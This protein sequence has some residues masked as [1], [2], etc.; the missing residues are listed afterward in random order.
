MAVRRIPHGTITLA[1]HQL[2][3]GDGEP[4]LLLHELGGASGSWAAAVEPWPGA[5]FALDLAGHGASEWRPGGAY[6]PELFAA[7]VDAAVAVLGPCRVAGAGLGAY[8]ALL[9]AGARPDLVAA[10]LL[11]PGRGLDGGGPLPDPAR[12]VPAGMESG[13][14]GSDPMVRACETD[15]RPVDYARA[16]ARGARQ[17]LLAEDGSARPPWWHG[18]REAPGVRS[19]PADPAVALRSLQALR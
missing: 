5:V 4:L 8:V 14:S 1:L 18:V 15:V 16:F 7:D 13:G 10:A 3:A 9:V 17:L 2:R 12:A 11:L 19:V 6:T